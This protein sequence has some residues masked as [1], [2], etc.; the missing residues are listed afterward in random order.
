MRGAASRQGACGQPAGGAGPRPRRDPGPQDPVPDAVRQA[1]RLPDLPAAVVVPVVA[2]NVAE[3]A[4]LEGVKVDGIVHPLLDDVALEQ[5]G[6]ED[7]RPVVGRED[8]A[9]DGEEHRERDRVEVAVDVH[10]VPGTPVMV[11]VHGVE[12]GVH[13]MLQEA[14]AVG[15]PPVEDVAVD[16][17]LEQGPEDDAQ[18]EVG[19]GMDGVEDESGA[20]DRH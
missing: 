7:G 16:E 8:E 4:G 13:P 10:P 9:H 19:Q 1:E 6:H 12:E 15:K 3:V 14:R 17:V 11:P 20:E 18:G 5:G 2:A